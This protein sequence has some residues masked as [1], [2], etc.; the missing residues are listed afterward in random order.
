MTTPNKNVFLVEVTSRL[1]GVVPDLVN[2]QLKQVYSDFLD[3]TNA[4]WQDVSVAIDTT[5]TSYDVSPDE[6]MVNRALSIKNGNGSDVEADL[7]LQDAGMPMLVLRQLVSQADTY[8]VRVSLLPA[9]SQ[10]LTVPDW[11]F[12]KYRLTLLD[13]VLGR[14]YAMPMKP[15]TSEQLA[16]Y[17]TR[18]YNAGVSRARVEQTHSHRWGVNAWRFPSS[19]A[20]RRWR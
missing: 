8:T 11:M 2:M 5:N 15:F 16:I 18:S 19:F 17:H 14:M 3:R 13:G 4:W 6:G 1:P 12:D 7:T 9:P 20:T 10:P